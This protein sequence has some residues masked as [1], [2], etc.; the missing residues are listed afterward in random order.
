MLFVL[1]VSN[2]VSPLKALSKILEDFLLDSF[3]Y[4]HVTFVN[5]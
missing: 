1:I 3:L 4:Q 2:S 5:I